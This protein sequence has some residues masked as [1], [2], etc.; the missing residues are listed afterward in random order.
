LIFY[1]KFV[2]F[3]GDSFFFR[4]S[5]IVREIRNENQKRSLWKRAKRLELYKGQDE[6]VRSAKKQVAGNDQRVFNRSL[7][8]LIPLE[9][10]IQTA[11]S[12]VEAVS[13]SASNHSSA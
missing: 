1:Y 11:R 7:K 8:H 4:A 6:E 3:T 2:G 9:C 13:S 10:S 5:R 12:N